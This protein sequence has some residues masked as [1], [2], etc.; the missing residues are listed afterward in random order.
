MAT[1]TP[2]RRRTSP[3]AITAPV[4]GWAG[5]SG[6]DRDGRTDEQNKFWKIR[7]EEEGRARGQRTPYPLLISGLLLLRSCD[8]QYAPAERISRQLSDLRLCADQRPGGCQSDSHWR[9]RA[10]WQEI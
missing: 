6:T 5:P 9:L 3:V 8:L 10:P 4:Q 1:G 2:G 7:P